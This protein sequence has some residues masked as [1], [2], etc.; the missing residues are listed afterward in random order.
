MAI[1]PKDAAQKLSNEIGK[2]DIVTI[3]NGMGQQEST[4]ELVQRPCS[5]PP[6]LFSMPM[7]VGRFVNTLSFYGRNFRYPNTTYQKSDLSLPSK[8]I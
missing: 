5:F 3:G 7:P 6:V 2:Y 8:P 1:F 4:K